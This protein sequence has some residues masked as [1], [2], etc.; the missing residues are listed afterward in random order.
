MAATSPAGRSNARVKWDRPAHS[1]THEVD[2]HPAAHCQMISLQA[3]AT[4]LAVSFNSLV[5]NFVHGFR[6]CDGI[7]GFIFR[8]RFD[9]K[10]DNT[11]K[12]QQ[13]G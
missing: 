5:L 4:P 10:I 8:V 3:R 11:N 13:S 9:N 12:S 1:L 2:G 6:V 7:E